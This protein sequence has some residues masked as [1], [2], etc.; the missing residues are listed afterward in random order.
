MTLINNRINN[1]Y[2]FVLRI[3]FRN[4]QLTFKQ[5]LMQNGS[6]YIHQRNL[7]ILPTEIFKTTNGLKPVIME[8]VF[9]FKHLTNNFQNAETLNRSNV[10]SHKYRTETNTSSGGNILP[11]DYKALRSLNTNVK[12]QN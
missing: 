5:S 9:K 6:V 2:E 10:N 1:I 4:Y 3:T 12:I 7:Q 8:D 11:N